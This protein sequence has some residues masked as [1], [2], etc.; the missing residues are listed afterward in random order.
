MVKLRFLLKKIIIPVI[1]MVLIITVFLIIKSTYDSNNKGEIKGS[2]TKLPSGLNSLVEKQLPDGQFV[3]ILDHEVFTGLG[4]ALLDKDHGFIQWLPEAEYLSPNKGDKYPGQYVDWWELSDIN[5]DGKTELAIELII[6]GS[7][8]SHPFH[9]YQY[10]DGSFRLLLKFED[11][12][13]H[14]ELVDLDNNS[15]KEILYSF[16]L[17]SIGW[18]ERT[19]IPW[20]EVWTWRDGKYQ[21]ANNL[22]PD[23][24]QEMLLKYDE[25]M[26]DSQENELAQPYQPVIKCLEEKAKLNI[27][28]TLADGKDCRNLIHGYKN[29]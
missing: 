5:N 20:K 24:Y 9:L 7:S 28:G 11:G 15:S 13:N 1:V 19:Y 8:L 4:I 12:V 17:S 16:A 23:I 27:S 3:A 10:L 6:S 22:Y 18:Y 25:L 29:F 14:T 2:F 21:L 26:K